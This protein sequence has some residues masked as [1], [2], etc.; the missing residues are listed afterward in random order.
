M[1]LLMPGILS[2]SMAILALVLIGLSIPLI[3]GKVTTN[4]TYGFRTSRTM[5]NPDTWKRANTFS[6]WASVVCGAVMLFLIPAYLKIALR[7]GL[8][9][10]QQ[11]WY[12]FA[13]EVVPLAVLALTLFVYNQT[14]PNGSN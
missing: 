6:G 11:A 12:G 13:F 5:S 14:L 2:G 7:P 3:A 4:P 8:T 1:R 10:T 9:M